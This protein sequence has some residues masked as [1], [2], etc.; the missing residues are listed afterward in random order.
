ME[1]TAPHISCITIYIYSLYLDANSSS[2]YM[3]ERAGMTM[4]WRYI[5][6]YIIRY[7]VSKI[8]NIPRH[9]ADYFGLASV[10]PMRRHANR[11]NMPKSHDKRIIL[12][13][14]MQ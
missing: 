6:Q 4:T 9:S 14:T 8:Y 7:V 13:S 1:Q 11:I 5:M 12:K 2:K 10:T 3:Q